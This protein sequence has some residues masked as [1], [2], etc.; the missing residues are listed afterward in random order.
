MLATFS[1][2]GNPRIH[3]DAPRNA[4][5][6]RTAAGRVCCVLT[7]ESPN[8]VIILSNHH[9]FVM[10]HVIYN[11]IVQT[12]SP[13]TTSIIRNVQSFPELPAVSTD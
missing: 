6:M 7:H 12:L 1:H 3:P 13:F 11:I 4:C 10:F 8:Q 5:G 9:V 2:K